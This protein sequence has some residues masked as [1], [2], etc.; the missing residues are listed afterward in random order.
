VCERTTGKLRF[1]GQSR[2]N[3]AMQ[4]ATFPGG[5]TSFLMPTLREQ[6]DPGHPL[7]LLAERM[8]WASFEE[9]FAELYSAEGRPAKPVRLMVSLLLLKQMFNL[10]DE[11]SGARWPKGGAFARRAAPE[12][13]GK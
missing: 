3:D 2:S 9:A 1:C 5:Q 10:G 11:S 7:R 8:P 4:S 6:L 12:G 13:A